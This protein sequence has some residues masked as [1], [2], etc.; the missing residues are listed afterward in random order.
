MK[1]SQLLRRLLCFFVCVQQHSFWQ[2]RQ[3]HIHLLIFLLAATVGIIS[4]YHHE[5]WRDESQAFLIAR[6]S[7][8]IAELWNNVR[9]EGHPILWHLLLFIG[10]KVFPSVY[11]IQVIHLLIALGVVALV[12]WY[13]P[14]PLLQKFLLCFSYYLSF[15]YIVISR[16]YAIGVLLLFAAVVVLQKNRGERKLPWVALLLGLCVN[17][18]F[19]ALIIACWMFVYGLLNYYR[20]HKTSMFRSVQPYFAALIFGCFLIIAFLQLKP[21]PDRI[22]RIRYATAYSFNKVLIVAA[23]VA[24]AFYACPNPARQPQ[25]WETTVFAK[26]TSSAA[27]NGIICYLPVAFSVAFIVLLFYCCRRKTLLGICIAGAFITLLCFTYSVFDKGFARHTGAFFILAILAM[28]LLRPSITGGRMQRSL[29]GLFLSMLIVQFAGAVI[30]HAGDFT[31]TFSGGKE[32]AMFLATSKRDTAKVLVEPDYVATTIVHYARIKQVYYPSLQAW[33]SFVKF[34]DG[35]KEF[36]YSTIF[37][38]AQKE[39]IETMIFNSRLNDS[40]AAAHF[41]QLLHTTAQ[42]TAAGEQFYIYGK[43]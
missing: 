15:E 22:P 35:K 43:K 21:P 16:N 27:I 28:W 42:C 9:Y 30:S 7:K 2:K 3:Q 4:M 1:P 25:Y 29:N 31:Y 23:D 20:L 40:V 10:Y 6:D 12:L 32:A 24:H 17:T 18:N 5:M 37:S 13:S 11:C 41:F 36:S 33:G 8:S 39:E 26:W 19:Y 34:S 38:M 14:F